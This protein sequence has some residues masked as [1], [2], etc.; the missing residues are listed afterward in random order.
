M[1]PPGETR[2]DFLDSLSWGGFW[3][4][5]GVGKVKKVERG[6]SGQEG[7]FREQHPQKSGAT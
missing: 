7:P 1:D 4:M 3:R 2:K 5:K 6:L